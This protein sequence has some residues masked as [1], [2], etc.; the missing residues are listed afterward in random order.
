MRHDPLFEPVKNRTVPFKGSYL[1]LERLT[2]ILPDRTEAIREIVRVRNA[3]AILPVEK[4]GTVHLVRQ[5]RP[6]IEKT[7]VEI[8]A[9]IVEKNESLAACARRECEE[10]TGY[11]P[12]TLKKLITYA[13]AEGYS[14]G[15][16]TLFAGTNL[17]KT[18]GTKL[19]RTEFV[20]QVSM[21]LEKLLRMVRQNKI[22]D[23]K[24]ILCTMLYAT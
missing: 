4:D 22:I 6:A 8:P 5:H 3:V 23:S 7:I 17:V 9:G 12:R 24:T 14:T 15:Y 2:I 10:E 20:E 16:I 19:D 1:T 18:G 13:H 11:R 21:P